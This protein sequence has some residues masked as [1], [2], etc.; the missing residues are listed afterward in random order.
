MNRYLCIIATM[1]ITGACCSSP[2]H[3]QVYDLRC[4]NLV[5]PLGIDATNPHFSWKLS[6][7]RNGTKQKAYQILVATDSLSLEKGKADLWNSGKVKSS[8]NS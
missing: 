4:E 3:L 6:S 2:D 5:N 1:M 8:T 7:N